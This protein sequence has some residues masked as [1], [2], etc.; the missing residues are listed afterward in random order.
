[1]WAKVLSIL[2]M[3][4]SCLLGGEKAIDRPTVKVK[5]KGSNSEEKFLYD[6]GAQVSLL[7]KKSFRRISVD[8]RPEKINFNL[9][10]SGVSGS[11]LK[12]M[13]CYLIKLNVLGK[14]IEHPFF[15]T[16]I[17]GQSV[18]G[19]DLIKKF[20]ISLNVINNKPYFVNQE[21]PEATL[22][23]S[24]YIPARSRTCVNIKVPHSNNNSKDK[25]D[26]KLQVL[27]IGVERCHQIYSDEVLLKPDS[28]NLAH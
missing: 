15:V 18:I 5:L 20:G 1:M 26:A 14:E 27:Q 3:T 23:R 28:T 4:L 13:G 7:S 6:S 8:K 9:S 19:I 24:V 10:C 2:S 12:L 25:N 16:D 17:P 21:P 22:T 11:K